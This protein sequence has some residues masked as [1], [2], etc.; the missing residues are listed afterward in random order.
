MKKL[1]AAL[2]LLSAQT[3]YAQD[4]KTI[5]ANKASTS[6]RFPDVLMESGAGPKVTVSKN[7]LK[8]QLTIA[9][10]WVKGLLKNFTGAKLAYSNDYY[11]DI[12]SGGNAG[13]WYEATGIKGAYSSKMRFYAYYCYDNRNTIFTEAESGSFVEV[14]FNNVFANS[15]CTDIGV[16]T[17]NG[18]KAFKLFEKSRTDGRI[19]YYEQIAM[20]NV[21]D[22][23]YK[24]KN[25]FIIIRN[26]DQPVF[27][28]ITRK[29]YLQQLVKDV[30]AYKSR[31]IA[32]ARA[33]Y[34]PA[35]EAANKAS[36]EAELKR[37]DNSKMYTPAQMAPYRKR[38]IETWET[39]EQK[40]NKQ[41]SRIE[42]ETSEARNAL[43]EYLEKPQEWL[44]RGI[45]DFFGFSIYT[46]KAIR[47]YIDGM[48]TP[49]P[50]R[51]GETG[52]YVASINP[53][54][55]N[56]SL[57]TD[58]PQL[59]MVTL[60]KGTYPH[61]LKVARLVRQPGVLA[62]LQAIFT[63][64]KQPALPPSKISASA[65]TPAYLPKLNTLSPL[66]VPAGMKPSVVPAV[67]TNSPSPAVQVNIDMPLLSPKLKQLPAQP[68]TATAYKSYLLELHTKIAAAIKP[69]EKKKAD[70]YIKNKKLVQSKDI[71]NAALSAWLQYAPGASLYLYSKAVVENPADALAANNFAAFLMMGGLPEKAIP[72]LEYWNQQ[73]TG[74]A[75]L[76]ANLGN[77]YYRLGDMPAAMKYLLQ[78]VQK[79]SLHPTAN[80]LLCIMY[81]KKGDTQKA[82][83]HGTRSI[84]SCHDEQ[85]IAIL[86]K[87]NSKIRPGEVMSRF[88]RL[89][90]KE[91]PLLK[92][93]KLPVMPSSLDD[94]EPFAIELAAMKES[95]QMTIADI[96]AKS[97]AA[98]AAVQQK[99]LMA[100]FAG[101]ISPIRAKA[102]HIIMDGLQTYQEDAARYG[103]VF[104]YHLKK[105]NVPHNAS[106]KA[107]VKKY[108]DQLNKL[109]GGEGGD[110]DKIAALELARCNELNKEN[111]TYLSE[112]S[113]LTNQHAQQ[114]EYIHRKFYRDYANW[115]AYWM[116]GTTVSF[117]SIQ[118]DYLKSVLGI[119]SDYKLLSKTNCS[120]PE[121]E[122][123][124]AK[125]GTLQKWEDAYCANSK[126]KLAFIALTLTWTCTSWGIEG[127]E[128]FVGA[129]EVNYA[130][131]GTF[132]DFT[133]EAGVG[134]SFELGGGKLG[135]IE[136]GAS[137]K[138]F[139][140]IGTNK[141]TG[142]WEIK[143]VGIKSE[144]ALEG[145]IG[146]L[147]GE[148]K[149]IETSVAINAG[150]KTTG[151]L[152]P[153]LPID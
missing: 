27:I 90:Q 65:Y 114:L 40:L 91:F 23:I 136:I 21:Y 18:K 10:N 146:N 17:V 124:P 145:S 123:L 50:D 35:A 142:K 78:C 69:Q 151:V 1:L 99:V 98:S 25:E 97:P 63:P 111:Q 138:D 20:S 116:P 41:L 135:E 94:M 112:L 66:V 108:A 79:D 70:D 58:V 53:L 2:L 68:F 32:A 22:S 150:V 55:C 29:E 16:F 122:P 47:Q 107:I 67:P 88:P 26:S 126:G 137:V 144:I 31:E 13:K 92:R 14:T 104:Q 28:P 51:E 128:G 11:F 15:F 102:Q 148:I 134:E 106:T 109:E 132:E 8:P 48:D 72:I 125:N 81:L 49:H 12:S 30:E 105:L 33:A 110:E 119:L 71:S 54:Y 121:S 34:S 61:M 42:T 96:E 43:L 131:D 117:P 93:I 5:A 19:D 103:D 147:G 133:L 127:G 37:I 82:K 143:D 153:L 130:D 77:A 9:E 129:L 113:A 57:T 100:S 60:R 62:P 152:A 141:A 39:E 115:A 86:R 45:N 36:L 89:P 38:L 80:K 7:A 84:S 75:S 87:L 59:I 52:T 120:V 44:N 149:L 74:D 140:K 101:G 95:I 24:S 4:C 73:K 85:V 76:L 83:D 6:V 139:V 64:G 118:R 56:K 3:N 46:G